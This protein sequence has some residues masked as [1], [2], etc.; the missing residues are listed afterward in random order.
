MKTF[1]L[2]RMIATGIVAG[3]IGAAINSAALAVMLYE[4]GLANLSWMDLLGRIGAGAVWGVG[5]AF[6]YPWLPKSFIAKVVFA[7]ALTTAVAWMFVLPAKGIAFSGAIAVRSLVA[8]TV[9]GVVTMFVLHQV[10][11]ALPDA[12]MGRRAED[13][14][15]NPSGA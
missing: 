1:S 7:A 3:A 2:P 4:A 5:F 15:D 6:A 14:Q 12:N 9:Y 10:Y 11:L 8:N 13:F